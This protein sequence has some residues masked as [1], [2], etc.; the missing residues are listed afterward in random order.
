MIF[1]ETRRE[2]QLIGEVSQTIQR[3]LSSPFSVFLSY[4][5]KEFMLGSTSANEGAM[6]VLL[7]LNK[8]PNGR[9]RACLR[10]QAMPFL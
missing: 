6:G 3:L 1:L 10:A 8:K 5:F 9:G 4:A 2:E 7:L